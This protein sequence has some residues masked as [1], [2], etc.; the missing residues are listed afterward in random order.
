[1][2]SLLIIDDNEKGALLLK[3]GLEVTSQ[4]EAD[5]VISGEEGIRQS[6]KKNYDAILMDLNLPGIDGIK[7]MQLIKED[8]P[9]CPVIMITGHNDIQTA[10]TAI[11]KGAFDY[12]V[13]PLD[14]DMVLDVI[15]RAC[16]Q[17]A[18]EKK[19]KAD[20]KNKKIRHSEE[21][22]YD[23]EKSPLVELVRVSG[24]VA[25]SDAPVLITGESGTGK[26]LISK[27]IHAKSVRSNQPFV[28]V[29]C[30]A[31]P[32]E[33]MESEF[34]GH[35][36]GAFTGATE[37][38][39]GFFSV[40][41]KGTIFLDE[42]GEMPM[43]LQVKLL[44]TLQSGE[45]RRIGGTKLFHVDVRIIAATSRNLLDEI[46]QN[47][48]R[49][50]L[51]YRLNVVNICIPPL[52]ERRCDIS[53]LI[54]HF[55]NILHP[56]DNIVRKIDDKALSFLEK[57]S[58]PGNIRELKNLIER[59][60]LLVEGTTITLEDV[61]KDSL[62]SKNHQKHIEFEDMSLAKLEAFQIDAILKQCEG[63]KTKA[64]K[65]LGITI[66]T[67]YNKL[68]KIKDSSFD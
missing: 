30:G 17:V 61:I 28:E 64:A 8:L 50:D 13:K 46:E 37:K 42:I 34:F 63:N 40:A 55:L 21:M 45:V 11:K 59:F 68:S 58:W 25:V 32:H 60:M 6:I 66:Q 29:N 54:R 41:N 31:I 18:L 47:R 43:S 9:Y 65:K 33:L 15:E 3:K 35:E 7:A 4:I 62:I 51:F 52:R 10:V 5:L 24:K 36:K 49:E 57:H 38:H 44:R 26:E 16:K 53:L 67:L 27:M 2:Y 12:L 23:K 22:V 39:E 48:F 56:G 20:D 14:L 19:I 1:M